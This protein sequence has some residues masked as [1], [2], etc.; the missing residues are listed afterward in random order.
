METVLRQQIFNKKYMSDFKFELLK[1]INNLNF[2][3]NASGI[4]CYVFLILLSGI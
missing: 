4:A 3:P 1:L 2:V